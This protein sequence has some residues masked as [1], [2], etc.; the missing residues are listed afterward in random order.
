MSG[1]PTSRNSSQLQQMLKNLKDNPEL[2]RIVRQNNGQLPTAS[3]SHL[4]TISKQQNFAYKYHVKM[5]LKDD[6]TD[7]QA[8]RA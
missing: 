1:G 4:L 7:A 8:Q 6:V 3:Y 5:R 2:N